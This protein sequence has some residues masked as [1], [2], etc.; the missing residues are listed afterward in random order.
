[1]TTGPAEG[2]RGMSDEMTDA[3]GGLMQMAGGAVG[4]GA[5][6]TTG[7]TENGQDP[8]KDDEEEDELVVD[9]EEEL[10]AAAPSTGRGRGRRGGATSA[11]GSGRGRKKTEGTAPKKAPRKS[12]TK[13]FIT[14]ASA[15]PST[16]TIPTPRGED[17][18]GAPV[19]LELMEID[20]IADEDAMSTITA[21]TALDVPGALS[22]TTATGKKRRGG[23]GGPG[24]G[25]GRKKVELDPANDD[26]EGSMPGT[27]A[28]TSKASARRKKVVAPP[29]NS[30][31]V[32]G[33][34]PGGVTKN[35]PQYHVMK[36]ED[37]E[38]CGRGD[39]QVRR[40]AAGNLSLLVPC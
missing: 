27:P 13:P 18:P 21:S 31:D 34:G 4:A 19:P 5:G 35:Q 24:T 17:E 32:N 16:P 28:S 9:I 12:A 3:V 25:R 33:Q 40:G 20:E 10:S 2:I 26:P 36:K 6:S 7:E 30:G 8:T 38:M 15:T 23:K 14:T 37:G 1:M 39:I 29:S 11:G 22:S